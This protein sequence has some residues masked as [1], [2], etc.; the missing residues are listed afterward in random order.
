MLTDI[1]DLVTPEDAGV[2]KPDVR[3]FNHALRILAVSAEEV[4]MIGDDYEC[5]IAPAEKLGMQTF[6]V[7]RPENRLGDVEL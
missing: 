4:M 1:P 5:D 3:I 7:R 6:W 2:W